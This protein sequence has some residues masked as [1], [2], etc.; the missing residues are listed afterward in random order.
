MNF[1]TTSADV[2][3]NTEPIPEVHY[4]YGFYVDIF[5]VVLALFITAAVSALLNVFLL[6]VTVKNKSLHNTYNHLL[7]LTALCDCFHCISYSISIYHSLIGRNMIPL[8][9]CFYMQIY[10]VPAWTMSCALLLLIAVDRL[11]AVLR[12]IWHR[13]VNTLVYVSALCT[14]GILFSVYI[15]VI[16]Y[17]YAIDHSNTNVICMYSACF[18]DE[19]GVTMFRASGIVGALTVACY[20]T[21]WLVMKRTKTASF[22]IAK[23]TVKSLA[24]IM[25]CVLVSWGLNAALEIVVPQKA[26]GFDVTKWLITRLG[27]FAINVASGSNVVFLYFF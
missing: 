19:I 20:L 21:I 15:F 10:A 11:I 18:L 8:L 1:S 13:N 6:Y 23:R 5:L 16:A 12:P 26:A 2:P 25:V 4:E 27:A 7:A 9:P 14:P 3:V 24:A 17:R 22:R